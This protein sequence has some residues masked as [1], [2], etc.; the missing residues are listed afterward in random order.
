ML[1][2]RGALADILSSTVLA[3]L[4]RG[5]GLLPPPPSL[6]S[7]WCPR[8][9]TSPNA[10]RPGTSSAWQ[11]APLSA[12]VAGGISTAWAELARCSGPCAEVAYVSAFALIAIGRKCDLRDPQPAQ[13]PAAD[14]PSRQTML[15]GF[16]FI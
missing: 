6:W 2:L 9:R 13:S 3:P 14:R 4:R 10:V 12:R 8:P 16:R 5:A 7:A 1:Q 15:A 11:A